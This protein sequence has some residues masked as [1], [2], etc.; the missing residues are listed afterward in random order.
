MSGDRDHV[1]RLFAGLGFDAPEHDALVR[2]A[3]LLTELPAPPDPDGLMPRYEELRETLVARLR[4]DDTDAAEE[5]LLELYAHL[6]G[7]EAP[8]T[9]A[10][11][12]T[13]DATGGHWCHAGGPSPVLRAGRYLRPDSVSADLGAG[14]GLQC[15]LMLRLHPHAA[16]EQVELSSRMVEAG[17][18]LQGWLGLREDQV[19]WKVMDVTHYEPEGVDF[20][21]LYR[22]VRPEGEGAAY[23]RRLAAALDRGPRPLTVFAVAD[24]LGPFLPASF[25]VVHDDGHLRCY[26]RR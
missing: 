24:P 8:Y 15:L 14:N 5:A 26:R 21:Y 12:K 6:H 4:G 13:V 18:A 23:Y 25:E 17:R 7:H 2:L 9:A 22:P 11:R 10:E 1:S 20:L 16:S 19:R 3:L